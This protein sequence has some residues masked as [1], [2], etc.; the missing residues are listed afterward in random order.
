MVSA[1]EQTQ[2]TVLI[3]DSGWGDPILGVVIGV[4][5][6]PAGR[7]FERRILPVFFQ[8]PRFKRKDYLERAVDIVKE[9]IE[10]MKI[11]KDVNFK[12][13]QGYVLSGIRRYLR[14]QGYTVED[15]V[16]KG[17]LQKRIEKS[18]LKWCEDVGVPEHILQEEGG[19]PR[20]WA[21]INWVKENPKVREN[22]VKTGWKS[23]DERWKA[24][25]YS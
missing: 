19:K 9:A 12:V 6:L 20:F 1:A 17:D 10:V 21:L 23:W 13:C 16:I 4:L 24:Y 3:D 11:E 22:L 14:N 15:T 5:D 2:R 18:Y 8:P 25:V 7:Y